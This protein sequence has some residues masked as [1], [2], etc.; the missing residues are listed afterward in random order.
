MDIVYY[1]GY[2]KRMIK[3]PLK[4]LMII[5]PI[6][7]RT[8]RNLNNLRNR[9]NG[10]R[11]NRTKIEEH[12]LLQQQQADSFGNF[13]PIIVVKYKGNSYVALD[14]NG[15]IH[16][17]EKAHLPPDTLIEVM[18]YD[19]GNNQE[20]INLIEEKRKQHGFE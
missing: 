7:Y 1:S 18:E 13:K 2:P 8:I 6:N 12:G 19:H 16:A 9:A 11:K 15:R 17:I 20:L 10:V 5:H 3:I 4:D 14:G